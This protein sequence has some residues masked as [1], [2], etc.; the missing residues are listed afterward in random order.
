MNLAQRKMHVSHT[1]HM[2]EVQERTEDDSILVDLS[3]SFT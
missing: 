1:C 3:W 2:I